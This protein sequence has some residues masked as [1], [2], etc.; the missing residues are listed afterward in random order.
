MR[1]SSSIMRMEGSIVAAP[2]TRSCYRRTNL[3]L[4]ALPFKMSRYPTFRPR[5][6]LAAIPCRSVT[7]FPL[8]TSYECTGDDGGEHRRMCSV[9]RVF[10][11]SRQD[12]NG[13]FVPRQEVTVANAGGSSRRQRGVLP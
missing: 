1:R 4:G 3:L 10:D 7:Y 2:R 13:E 12:R 8:L 5:W 6:I 11:R 9:S